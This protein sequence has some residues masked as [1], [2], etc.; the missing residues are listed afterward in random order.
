MSL[1]VCNLIVTRRHQLL[2]LS[3]CAVDAMSAT[4]R[5]LAAVWVPCNIAVE[6]F[7]RARSVDHIVALCVI[8]THFPE[9]MTFSFVL[10]K[11]S[12]NWHFSSSSVDLCETLCGQ[13]V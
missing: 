7:A 12:P 5:F 6:V 2:G 9:A 8:R 1:G 13:V 11:V 10:L 3:G 4:E